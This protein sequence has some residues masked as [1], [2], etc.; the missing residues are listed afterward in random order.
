MSWKIWYYLNNFGRLLIRIG[1][2]WNDFF[3]Y[4]NGESILKEL[5]LSDEILVKI[6]NGHY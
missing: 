4:Y 1:A 3:R 6:N 2:I 5:S